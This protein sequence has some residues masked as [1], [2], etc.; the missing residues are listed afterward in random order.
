MLSGLSSMRCTLLSSL[1][2]SF[3][4][5]TSCRAR[6]GPY[7]TYCLST[8]IPASRPSTTFYEH[9]VTL[10]PASPT[11]FLTFLRQ[12]NPD[13]PVLYKHTGHSA[14]RTFDTLIFGAAWRDSS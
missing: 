8:T 1:S 12:A 10:S 5:Q 4:M 6:G 7:T 13:V 11:H 3:W 9:R 14:A 2:S